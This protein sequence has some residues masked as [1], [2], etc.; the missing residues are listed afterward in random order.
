[1]AASNISHYCFILPKIHSGISLSWRMPDRMTEVPLRVSSSAPLVKRVE[2]R[3][4]R[5]FEPPHRYLHS[6]PY[7]TF[8]T[9]APAATTATPAATSALPSGFKAHNS[10]V[11]QNKCLWGQLLCSSRSIINIDIH[12]LAGHPTFLMTPLWANINTVKYSVV[13]RAV[14]SR[15]F[16]LM[17]L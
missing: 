11:P 2:T 9:A 13:S 14:R 10:I 3:R 16:S 1:M 8:A 5:L 15:Y 12:L 6:Q 4:A 7:K 17:Y